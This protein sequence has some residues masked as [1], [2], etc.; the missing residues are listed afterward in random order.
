[1]LERNFRIHLLIAVLVIGCGLF[2][3]LSLSEWI[4]II[5]AIFIV[6]C[7]EL[8]NSIVERLIDYLK[9]E[10]HAEAKIIKDIAAATVLIAAFTSIALGLLIFIPKLL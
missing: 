6:L 4:I 10:I 7:A 2:F 1:M 5:I 9:P 8:M 3:Q